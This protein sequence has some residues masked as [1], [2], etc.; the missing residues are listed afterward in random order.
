MKSRK[1]P[2]S[3]EVTVD[4]LK[5]GDEPVTRWLFTFFTDVWKNEQMAKEWK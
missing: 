3:D 2:G 5:A 1:V 4:V